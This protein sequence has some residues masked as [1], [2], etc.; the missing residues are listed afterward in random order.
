MLRR[1]WKVADKYEPQW[2]NLEMKQVEPNNLIITTITIIIIPHHPPT[3]SAHARQ[4]IM[5]PFTVNLIQAMGITIST[6]LI[7][8]THAWINEHSESDA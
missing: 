5:S 1:C 8:V 2:F 4:N 3:Y 6:R 7:H